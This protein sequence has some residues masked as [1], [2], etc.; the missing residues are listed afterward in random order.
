M[1]L[2]V[3]LVVV[4]G[5][6]VLSMEGVI[7]GEFGKIVGKFESSYYIFIMGMFILGLIILFVGKGDL[8]YVL[9][10]FKW[11]L[12]GGLLGMVY[13]IILVISIFFIGI[14]VLMVVVIV[15]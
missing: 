4:L 12:I 3:Y 8:F 14:G 7:V 10:V 11:N 5:G 9:K 15:G 13:L 2:L 1:K 6:V